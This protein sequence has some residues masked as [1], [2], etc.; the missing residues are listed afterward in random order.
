MGR[1]GNWPDGLRWSPAVVWDEVFVM[2]IREPSFKT[3]KNCR[4]PVFFR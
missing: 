3:I 2:E 4:I 1:A